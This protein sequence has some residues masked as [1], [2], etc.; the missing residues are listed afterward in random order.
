MPHN[1]CTCRS[2]R[3]PFLVIKADFFFFGMLTHN[4]MNDADQAANRSPHA[5]PLVDDLPPKVQSL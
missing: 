1:L 5:S 3:R 2:T 4:G